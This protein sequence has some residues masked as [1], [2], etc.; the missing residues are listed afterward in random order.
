MDTGQTNEIM[1]ISFL[2]IAYPV[3]NTSDFELI[4]RYRR[5]HDE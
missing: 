1:K 5:D 4:Q 3:I 2:V